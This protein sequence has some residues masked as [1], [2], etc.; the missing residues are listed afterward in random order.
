MYNPEQRPSDLVKDQ[1]PDVGLS[2]PAPA[3]CVAAGRCTRPPTKRGSSVSI[4][5]LNGANFSRAMRSQVSSTDA[6]VSG[7]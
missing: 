2:D 7:E 4:R 1:L 3:A 5:R 6:K